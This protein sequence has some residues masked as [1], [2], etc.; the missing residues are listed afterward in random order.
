MGSVEAQE[1][2]VEI[3]DDLPSFSI[4]VTHPLK[5]DLFDPKPLIDFSE[6][7]EIYPTSFEA[8]GQQDSDDAD[9]IEQYKQLISKYPQPRQ[10]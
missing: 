3:D 4:P 5:T 6:I 2:D 10:S 8:V 1:A 7:N 9:I